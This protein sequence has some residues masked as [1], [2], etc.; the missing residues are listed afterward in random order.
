[1]G[2]LL[3]L[4]IGPA[5]TAA[6]TAASVWVR[7]THQRR[8]REHRRRRAI[9]QANQELTLIDAWLTAHERLR[10]LQL[11]ATLSQ[12]VSHDLEKA[13]A[14]LADPVVAE[15][16]ATEPVRSGWNISSFLLR[17]I[18]T[19]WARFARFFYYLFVLVATVWS[20][21][22]FAVLSEQGVTVGNVLISLFTAM[23]GVLPALGSYKLAR[24][25]DRA[26][27]DEGYPVRP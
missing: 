7:D 10:A 27:S 14:V 19:G 24:R 15:P 26:D 1:M 13:Y 2:E 17:D 20:I 16:I 25:A 21:A 18:R 8:D 23:F 11:H 12:R 3:L 5:V 9:E 22:S 6:V 4:L